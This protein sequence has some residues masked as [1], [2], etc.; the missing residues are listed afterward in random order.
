MKIKKLIV[1]AL[2]FS[3]LVTFN[4]Y[5]FAH[6]ENIE[7]PISIPYKLIHSELI[8]RDIN[9]VTY[10]GQIRSNEG[11]KMFLAAYSIRKEFI[12]ILNQTDFSKKI[13]VFGVTDNIRE[14]LEAFKYSKNTNVCF[15]DYYTSGIMYKLGPVEEG[16]KYSYIT[17][18]EID[19]SYKFPYI[20][21]RRFVKIKK[22][23]SILFK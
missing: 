12:D 17:I 2:V 13:L 16:K 14:R 11:L 23:L 21:I 10:S 6:E 15:L 3:S 1:F 19:N 22:G 18:I 7:K 4:P 5:S 20:R 9:D 8:Q